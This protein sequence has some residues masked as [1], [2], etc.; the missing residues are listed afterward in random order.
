VYENALWKGTTRVSLLPLTFSPLHSSPSERQRELWAYG[1]NTYKCVLCNSALYITENWENDGE[2]KK[3]EKLTRS[4]LM[5]LI[6]LVCVQNKKKK[7]FI[8]QCPLAAGETKPLQM[9][10]PIYI[11][12]LKTWEF[13]RKNGLQETKKKK[14]TH[15]A[16][17][18]N[19]VFFFVSP[20]WRKF[21][22]TNRKKME[23]LDSF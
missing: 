5:A 18:K 15:L 10:F 14:K 19:V 9:P 13:L 7:S 23:G 17:N 16:K 3:R 6:D 4:R 11:R 20:W 22:K 1:V 2:W 21:K 8:C 12:T